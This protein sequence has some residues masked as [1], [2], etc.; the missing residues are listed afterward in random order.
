VFRADY[1]SGLW[2]GTVTAESLDAS[3][4]SEAAGPW[5]SDTAT[6]LDAADWNSGRQVITCSEVSS[7]NTCRNAAFR[8]EEVGEAMRSRLGDAQTGPVVLNFLRG[9]RSNEAPQGAGLRP[10]ASVQGDI[11]HSPLTYWRYPDGT[12][13]LFVGGNDGMLHVFDASTGAE[14]YAYVPSMLAPT[15]PRLAR[16]PY[17]HTPYVDGGL[18]L[19]DVVIDGRTRTLL[20]GALGGGGKGLFLLDVTD[21]SAPGRESDLVSQAPVKW[22]VTSGS[23]GFANLGYTYA[24]PRLARLNSGHAA[25]VVGNGYLA[26]GSGRASLM[27]VDAQTGAMIREIEV[28][29]SASGAAYGLSTPTLVDLD[30]D[31]KADVAYAGD[32]DG[33]LWRF[34]LRGPSPANYSV[35]LL[36]SAVGGSPITTAPAVFSH[37]AGGTMVVFGS[38]STLSASSLV[39]STPQW[40]VGIW[41][42]APQGN[43]DWLEQ[44]LAEDGTSQ[45]RVRTLSARAPNWSAGGH[46]GWRLPLP[47]GERL[48]AEGMFIAEGR[49]HVTTTNPTIG[50]AS[51]E[52]RGSNWFMELDALS[53]GSPRA[54]IFDV[55]GDGS[56]GADDLLNGAVVVGRWLGTGVASQPVLADTAALAQT[57]FNRQSD[58]PY[59]PTTSQT[60]PGVSGGHF[61]ADLHARSTGSFSKPIHVHEYDDLF[62]V[63]GVNMLAPSKDT[64]RLSAVLAQ[65]TAFKV[66]VSNQ[67]LNPASLL[68]VGP[69]ADFLPVRE[70]GGQAAARDAQTLLDSL[71]VYALAAGVPG[72]QAIV[73]LAWKVPLDAF[74]SRDWWGD[75]GVPRAGLIPS[76]T[77]CVHDM[78]DAGYATTGSVASGERHNGALTIQLIAGNTPASALRL[79]RSQDGDVRYGW[80]V[81]EGTEFRTYVLAEYTFFWHHDNKKCYGA[82]GWTPSPPQDT[83]A[84]GKSATRAAQSS[85][86]ADGVFGGGQTQQVQS[87]VTKIIARVVVTTIAYTDGTVVTI[88][89]ADRSDGTE[90]VTTTS[91]QV[92]TT[93]SRGA[94]GQ[95]VGGPV[96][97]R[98]ASARVN[99]REVNRS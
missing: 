19:A 46:R 42:G 92:V 99:W 68:K 49:L 30:R 90:Q 67:Y 53:G 80:T 27:L 78:D 29:A 59:L 36:G 77:K 74:Q 21:S 62:D 43:S 75:G 1:R 48:V 81:R 95:T 38:G 15:L 51:Q 88:R 41:D 65:T 6:Q 66:L 58:N 10:R 28:D 7:S 24:S 86:P 97:T 50:R 93:R 31:G 84:S 57:V 17:V 70:F 18:A 63:N 37:P 56:V 23:A 8:W 47:A 89:Y 44:V 60:G 87:V 91:G 5:S 69:G 12:Q 32:L 22:E 13:R 11:L 64:M 76:E 35:R 55:N 45:T 26:A 83:S 82:S 71:P 96:Q 16:A 33:Q 73:N 52:D 40:L 39:D 9:D 79:N 54:S 34:D 20:A 85:D 3:V 25:V 2:T 14:V 4:A 61:D 72:T 98:R 94:S